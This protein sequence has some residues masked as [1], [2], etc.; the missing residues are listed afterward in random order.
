MDRFTVYLFLAIPL[1]FGFLH[2]AILPLLQKLSLC[3]QGT[4]FTYR[5]QP[6]VPSETPEPYKKYDIFWS[7]GANALALIL[8]FIPLGIIEEL[9][10]GKQWFGR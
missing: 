4:M 1:Y 7:F 6:G 9:G 8:S 2:L 3:L 10:Y 5:L